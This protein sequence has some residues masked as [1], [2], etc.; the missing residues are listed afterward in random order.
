MSKQVLVLN[1]G[2]EPLSLVSVRRAIVLLLR[3]KAELL[4]AT[5]QMLC[6][7]NRTIPVPLVIRLVHYVRLPHRRVP[8][9]RAAIML[10]DAYTCQYCGEKPGQAA[11]T[12]DHVIPRSRGGEHGWTNLATACKRCNQR[13]GNQTPEEA[14][15]QLIRRPF[16]PSY[17]ALVL[18]S[19]PVAAE[20]WERLMGV[21]REHVLGATA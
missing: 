15:M 6:A 14:G 10:R 8:P 11:L 3:E 18:L 4:E 2:Y 17:V 9:T 19:N 7:A 16:E 12:V 1:A 13:K 5:Q 20:R 21:S